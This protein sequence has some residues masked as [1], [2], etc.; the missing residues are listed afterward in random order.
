MKSSMRLLL[1][2]NV[3]RVGSSTARSLRRYGYDVAMVG[4]CLE[5]SALSERFD[6]GVFDLGLPDGDAVA[7]AARLLE[8]QTIDRAV[9]FFTREEDAPRARAVG[10]V[11][12]RAL[13]V[14]ELDRT[15][16][17]RRPRSRSGIHARVIVEDER[18]ERVSDA[19][20]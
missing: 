5:A 16:S 18:E 12:D 2:E 15:I 20:R 8:E 11:V 10:A 14:A 6:C 3:A 13:G 1:V 17:V 7:L 19:P 9:F 4:S